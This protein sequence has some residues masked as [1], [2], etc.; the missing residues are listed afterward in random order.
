MGTSLLDDINMSFYLES[1]KVDFILLPILDGEQC[2]N[3][4]QKP[5]VLQIS[6]QIQENWK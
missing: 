1:E 4:T 2:F 6:T 3:A 5:N